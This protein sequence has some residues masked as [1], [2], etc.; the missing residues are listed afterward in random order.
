MGK[1]MDG[2]LSRHRAPKGA[3]SHF[4]IVH[5]VGVRRGAPSDLACGGKVLGVYS[6]R[7]EVLAVPV[8]DILPTLGVE[9]ASRM[10]GPKRQALL[11][12]VSC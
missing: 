5:C 10:L 6:R 11:F 7:A 4:P 9:L 2:W 8:D 12:A 3:V 1:A